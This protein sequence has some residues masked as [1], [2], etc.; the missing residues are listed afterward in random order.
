MT[1]ERFRI[2]IGDSHAI[3]REGLVIAL[4]QDPQIEVVGQ[5]HDGVDLVNQLLMLKPHI[6][7]LDTRLPGLIC[8]VTV[9]EILAQG[10]KVIL[11]TE[12]INANQVLE[13][14]HLGINSIILKQDSVETV[15]KAIHTVMEG[16]T[17]FAES[18][19]TLSFPETRKRI[20]TDRELEI[21]KLIAAGKTTKEI[22]QTLMC[23]DNTVKTHKTSLMAKAGVKNS[24]ELTAWAAKMSLLGP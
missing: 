8:T 18:L 2:F 19:Q 11:F 17:F 16:K 9:R 5:S 20:L 13:A 12:F 7:I 22:A 3:L 15:R 23:S 10:F 1:S 21:V 14:V 6:V 4:S 24:A